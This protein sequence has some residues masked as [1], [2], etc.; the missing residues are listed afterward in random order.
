[1]KP[2]MATTMEN[3]KA[4]KHFCEVCK[5]FQEAKKTLKVAGGKIIN[6]IWAHFNKFLLR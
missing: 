1:M 2:N 4:S 6:F 5:G 3:S